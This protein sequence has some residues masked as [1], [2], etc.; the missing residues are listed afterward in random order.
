MFAWPLGDR[1][2]QLSESDS[3]LGL[4]QKVG[5]RAAARDLLQPGKSRSATGAT[6]ASW[7]GSRSFGDDRLGRGAVIK[8]RDMS[9]QLQSSPIDSGRER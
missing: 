9:Q 6:P 3:V 5:Y 1:G 4:A 2:D 8:A 7:R